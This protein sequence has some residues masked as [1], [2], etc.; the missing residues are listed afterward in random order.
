MTNT[1]DKEKNY[2]LEGN[3]DLNPDGTVKTS[4]SNSTNTS[5]TTGYDGKKCQENTPCSPWDITDGAGDCIIEGYIA[6]QLNISGAIL[7]VNKMLGVYEQGSL[8]D[9]NFNGTALSGG[10]FPNFP[11]DNAFDKYITEFR[12]IQLGSDVVKTSYLGYDFGQI[13]LDNDRVR[14]GIETS[15][16]HDVCML[17]IKQGCNK[18]NR[19]S[20]ARVEHSDDG[21]KWYGVSK[22]QLPDCDNLITLNFRKSSP[23]RFW[24]IRPTKFNGGPEDY[25]VVQALQFIDYEY[26]N[27]GNIQDRILLENRD[28][29]YD[30]NVIRMKCSYTPI[31]ITA[32]EAK[33]G[34]FQQDQF[35]I[36]VSFAQTVRLLGRPFIIGDII[37]LPSE[38]QYS[39]TLQ[40]VKKYLEITDVAWSTDGYSPSWKPMMQRL[41]ATP[42]MSSQETQD[43]FGK[44]TED[45]DNSGLIDINDGNSKMYQDLSDISKTISAK[46]N[47]NVPERGEDDADI[48]KLSDD[49]LQ[50]GQD[51]D[52]NIKPIDRRRSEYGIDGMPPN[53]M[54]FTEGDAFPETP[55]NGDYHRLTYTYL[56]DKDIPPRLYRFSSLKNHWIYI[57]TDRRYQYKNTK[58]YL[59][60]F[61]DNDGA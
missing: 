35:S 55:K 14:Y 25:W 42:V 58:P 47:D 31:D 33:Q 10:Y 61:I 37:E 8:V 20:E 43:I 13:K 27:E 57:E 50:Y 2:L 7:N 45:S 15:I 59:Q 11:D 21:I 24:R 48:E 36:K 6:E 4:I 9:L 30:K 52:L 1:C 39:R 56:K 32:M 12:S 51:H 26:T 40:P 49:L 3:C 18:N 54:P 17:K 16:K 29:D 41:L 28:R 23:S 46:S 19:I 34:F 22:I 38:V 60:E 5:C 53:G 44:L